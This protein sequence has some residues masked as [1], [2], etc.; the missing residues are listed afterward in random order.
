M[1]A[2]TEFEVAS[3][4]QNKLDDR[5]VTIHVGPGGRFTA[6]GY[7]LALLIQRAYG[8]MDWNIEG[9]PAWIRSD[10]FDVVATAAVTGNLQEGQLQQMLRKLLADRFGLVVHKGSKEMAGHA[11]VVARSGVKAKPASAVAEQRDSF[12]FGWDG[13]EGQGVTMPD[14]ARW[15]GGKLGW[16]AV[17][18]TGLKGPYD[19]KAVWKFDPDRSTASDP[20]EEF[21]PVVMDALEAQLGLKMIR[22]KIR[23]ETIVID[24]V[25]R[26]SEN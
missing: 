14:F 23:I 18:H 17:D 20:K 11:L 1:L 6:R 21:R 4:R 8:V 9:G 25:E 15:V 2:Q 10:R 26:L 3:V 22:Q 5:I 7:T 24:R 16:I 12:R 19:F 13:V